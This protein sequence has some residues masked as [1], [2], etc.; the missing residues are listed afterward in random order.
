[1]VNSKISEIFSEC[2]LSENN[3]GISKKKKL[4]IL[5]KKNQSIWMAYENN[6][7]KNEHNKSSCRKKRGNFM[8]TF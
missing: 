8:I 1:M 3:L 6:L 2:T 5:K 4:P 7:F